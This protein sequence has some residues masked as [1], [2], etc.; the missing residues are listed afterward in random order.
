VQRGRAGHVPLLRADAGHLVPRRTVS[1]HLR[2]NNVR[3]RAD[4]LGARV[5]VHV[6]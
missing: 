6:A 2:P 1:L 3:L 4:K 5:V